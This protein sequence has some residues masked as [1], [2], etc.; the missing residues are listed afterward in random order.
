MLIVV[1]L[2]LLIIVV[3]TMTMVMRTLATMMMR[4]MRSPRRKTEGS[5]YATASNLKDMTPDDASAK[6]KDAWAKMTLSKARKLAGTPEDTS[7]S[8]S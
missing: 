4:M 1:G 5:E 3:N 8:S 2:A 7:S 6:R